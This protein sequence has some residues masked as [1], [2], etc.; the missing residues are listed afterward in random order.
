MLKKK[1]AC[2]MRKDKEQLVY[3]LNK[4]IAYRFISFWILKF[5]TEQFEF[6]LVPA[7]IVVVGIKGLKAGVGMVH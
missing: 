6:G 2:L 4:I 5:N 3:V 7:G 1:N